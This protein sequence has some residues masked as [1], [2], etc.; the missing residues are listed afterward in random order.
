MWRAARQGSKPGLGPDAAAFAR[1][2]GPAEL[3]AEARPVTRLLFDRLAPEQIAE[4]RARTAGAWLGLPDL[5]Q[6]TGLAS[7]QAPAHIHAMV[8]GPQSGAGGLYEAD[9]VIGALISAGVDPSEL[10]TGFDF[11]CSSG[12][13]LRVLR[14]A[15][16]ETRWR[17]CDPNRP[18]IEW[19]AGNLPGIDFSVSPQYPP[20]A[21]GDGEFDLVY[22]ISIW[23]HFAPSLGAR[24]FAEMHRLLRPGGHLVFT[25]H[26]PQSIAFYV[27]AGK[28]SPAQAREIIQSMYTRGTWY[29][30]EFGYTG[31]DGV[32]NPDWGT[33]FLSPEWVLAELCPQWRVLEYA[34]GR[35]QDNQD[36]YVLQRV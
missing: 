1:N 29:A 5:L 26:G 35:N 13:V 7:A 25:T 19:A 32:V 18:A 12:R 3:A 15:Y 2:V 27:A 23:S 4:V 9:M 16:P 17:G 8:H 30:P 36:V 11:G 14:A 24:W 33:A 28:R 20:L 21:V 31:D 34:P 22:A 10:K 6:R